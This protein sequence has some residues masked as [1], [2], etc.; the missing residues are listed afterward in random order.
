MKEVI[1]AKRLSKEFINLFHPVFKDKI[2]DV[3]LENDAWIAGGFA[4]KIAHMYFN[5]VS[6]THL[7]AHET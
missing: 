4:R 7:R 1:E 2:I 6:Y 3:C 5:T